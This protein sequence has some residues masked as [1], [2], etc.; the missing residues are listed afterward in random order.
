M[1][2]GISDAVLI[3]CIAAAAL[4]A[5]VGVYAYVSRPAGITPAPVSVV[6]AGVAGIKATLASHPTQAKQLGGFYGA[7]AKAIEGSEALKTTGQFRTAHGAA[8]QAF[9]AAA[10]YDRSAPSVGSQI[11]AFLKS[12]LGPEDKPLDAATKAKLVGAL[13]ALSIGLEG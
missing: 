13:K 11:D 1:R 3:A 8:L 12:E 9:T 4:V 10:G 6:P 2:R 7:W 5:S